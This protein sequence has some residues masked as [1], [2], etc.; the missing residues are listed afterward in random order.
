MGLADNISREYRFELDY[1]LPTDSVHLPLQPSRK[2]TVAEMVS[3]F[4][5]EG[6][7]EVPK[8]TRSDNSLKK[9][10]DVQRS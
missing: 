6:E 8:R 9:V 2:G 3:G 7:E 10:E 5:D 1:A 4:P